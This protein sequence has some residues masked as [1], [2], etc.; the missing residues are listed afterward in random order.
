MAAN[1]RPHAPAPTGG[2]TW[3]GVV[4]MLATIARRCRSRIAASGHLP[5]MAESGD[6]SSEKTE[7]DGFGDRCGAGCAPEFVPDVRDMTV[8]GVMADR[9]A[10][11]DLAVAQPVGDEREDLALASR[12]QRGRGGVG[13]VGTREKRAE[14]PRHGHPVADPRKM[15]VP[16][17]AHE[18]CPPGWTRR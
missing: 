16:V 3:S 8:H 14:R 15:S 5:A 4:V 12:Q 9:D 7:P 2:V 18:P 13:C 1:S 10:F 6:R 17:D 11:G